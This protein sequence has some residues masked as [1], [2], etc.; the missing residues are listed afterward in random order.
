MILIDM[1]MPKKCGDCP[2]YCIDLDCCEISFET[3]SSLQLSR[4]GNCPLQE[5]PPHGDLI[6]RDNLDIF[7]R[8]EQALEDYQANPDDEYLEGL[9]DG[10]HEAAKQIFI[11]P[12][13]IPA[14]HI[15]DADK[16]IE[17]EEET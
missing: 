13:V 4:Q 17:A 6:D 7:H 11:A 12:T 2:C 5:L 9:K 10:L 15:A 3:V 8:E 16:M 1:E 14:D